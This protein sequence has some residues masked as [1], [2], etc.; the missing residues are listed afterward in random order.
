MLVRELTS[1]E[2]LTRSG[3]C[4]AWLHAGRGQGRRGPAR[5][6]EHV[7]ALE[8]LPI[9]LA[10]MPDPVVPGA[11]QLAVERLIRNTERL[12]L[13]VDSAAP[14]VAPVAAAD[15]LDALYAAK[16]F[17][18]KHVL[19]PTAY[20]AL[21]QAERVGLAIE[22]MTY[23][24]GQGVHQAVQ[25]SAFDGRTAAYYYSHYGCWAWTQDAPVADRWWAHAYRDHVAGRE[26][27]VVIEGVCRFFDTLPK[28]PP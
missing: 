8:T 12:I 1:V 21:V 7:K 4:H 19:G 11:A 9:N 15:Y 20:D 27:R 10:D 5:F 22:G 2:D 18:R 24:R 28:P 13:A 6:D 17:W 26:V 23:L 14:D 3:R 16:E 25:L